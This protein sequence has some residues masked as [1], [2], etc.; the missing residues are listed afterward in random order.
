MRH[1]FLTVFLFSFSA[2]Y[3]SASQ[4]EDV[5]IIENVPSV[6]NY[7]WFIDGRS[8]VNCSGSSCTAYISEPASG[9]AEVHGAVLKLLRKNGIIVIAQC[10]GK[11]RIGADVLADMSGLAHSKTYR[12]CR[13]PEPGNR[14]IKAEFSTA[15]VKLTFTNPVSD[16][17]GRIFS[18]TYLIKGFLNPVAAPSL[19][20]FTPETG[21]RNMAC[22]PLKTRMKVHTAKEEHSFGTVP[23]AK[24]LVYVIQEHQMTVKVL[25]SF[26]TRV[27]LDGRWV[28]GNHSESYFY[29]PVDGGDH[30]VCAEWEVEFRNHVLPVS[31]AKFTAEPGQTYYLR[32]RVTFAGLEDERSIRLEPISADEGKSLVSRLPYS[33]QK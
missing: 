23:P 2:C 24:A 22:G 5:Q 19:V 16:P 18:E 25:G 15:A 4:P 13:M 14:E 12:D 33:E 17:S 8:T 30:Q 7:A 9:T 26:P 32:E 1:L 20:S 27:A 28:G 31:F 10:L 11:E 29:F 6:S 21:D 3:A